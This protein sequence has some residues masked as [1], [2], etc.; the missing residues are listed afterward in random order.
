MG[1]ALQE[2]WGAGGGLCFLLVL[3][4]MNESF[5]LPQKERKAQDPWGTTPRRKGIKAGPP[6]RANSVPRVTG[7]RGTQVILKM[8]HKGARACFA[9]LTNDP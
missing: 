8:M 9:A 6:D 7:Q 3:G 4:H 1:V 2:G 5:S